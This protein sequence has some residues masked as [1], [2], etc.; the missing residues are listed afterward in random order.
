MLASVLL[1]CSPTG[2]DQAQPSAAPTKSP[3]VLTEPTTT[4]GV[5]PTSAEFD[6]SDQSDSDVFGDTD[7]VQAEEV[8]FET[9]SD[10]VVTDDVVTDDVVTDSASGASQETQIPESQIPES[11]NPDSQNLESQI[12]DTTVDINRFTIPF[13]PTVPAPSPAAGYLSVADLAWNGV[14]VPVPPGFTVFA[15]AADAANANNL[16]QPV[17]REIYSV[18]SADAD[19]RFL[20]ATET[21][22]SPQ[23][24]V[25]SMVV[26]VG[27][28]VSSEVAFDL[29]AQ[30]RFGETAQVTSRR[31]ISWFGVPAIAGIVSKPD[32]QVQVA[33]VGLPDGRL[34]AMQVQGINADRV[35]QQLLGGF[36][37]ERPA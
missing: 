35:L 29:V 37:A 36:R 18:L 21:M 26:R 6:G 9:P 12:A 25:V 8:S 3:E 5:D 22:S 17:Q 34:V 10:D 30:R 28:R 16:Y 4:A 11:Q 15:T 33:A 24:T 20:V 23:P 19:R 32:A 13:Q 1:S 27:A 31:P 14:T 7:I 2:E